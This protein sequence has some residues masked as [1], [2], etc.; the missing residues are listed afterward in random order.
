MQLMLVVLAL[1]MT[2]WGSSFTFFNT[3]S[4]ASGSIGNVN[5][6]G[7]LNA[8]TTNINLVG[9]AERFR[10][11]GL[12]FSSG[13][14]TAATGLCTFGG[15]TLEVFNPAT[16]GTAIFTTSLAGL[17][18]DVLKG[19][20]TA[21]FMMDLGDIPALHCVG[22]ELSMGL[23]WGLSPASTTL[24]GGNARITGV[25]VIPEPSTL[26]LFATGLMSL[27]GLARRKL[28]LPI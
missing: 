2:A 20:G 18:G 13:C 25:N 4:F 17:T 5:S 3:G 12:T 24:V 15:G 28:R 14:A 23:T 8:T 9:T 10:I 21:V 1:S 7:G 6:T 27:A 19:T 22:C 11:L 26:G 16:A